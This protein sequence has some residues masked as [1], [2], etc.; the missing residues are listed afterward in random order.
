MRLR[1][2]TDI[3]KILEKAGVD[4]PLKHYKRDETIGDHKYPKHR[5][6]SDYKSPVVAWSSTVVKELNKQTDRMEDQITLKDKNE[7]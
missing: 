6:S 2:M 4:K 5:I 1:T 7:K 3:K